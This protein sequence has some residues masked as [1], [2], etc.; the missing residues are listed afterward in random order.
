M[1]HG[2]EIQEYKIW[3]FKEQNS[4]SRKDYN[5]MIYFWK[6]RKR[7][8]NRQHFLGKIIKSLLNI[9]NETVSHAVKQKADG[10]ATVTPAEWEF[11]TCR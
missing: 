7:K 4:H 3:I 2:K 1:E 10:I 9:C 11:L 8:S 6:K 5:T